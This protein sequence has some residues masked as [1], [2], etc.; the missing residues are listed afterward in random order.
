M[1]KLPGLEVSGQIQIVAIRIVCRVTRENK[2][3][4]QTG[5]TNIEHKITDILV[6]L[7][8]F[9][10][11]LVLDG[12]RIVEPVRPVEA[13]ENMIAFEWITLLQVPAMWEIDNLIV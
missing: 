3:V 4:R 5:R 13:H 11:E 10:R 12:P 2:A 6:K 1:L 8:P 7:L 9:E